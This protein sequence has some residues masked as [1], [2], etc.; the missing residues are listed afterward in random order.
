MSEAKWKAVVKKSS[1]RAWT[2]RMLKHSDIC[3]V[4]C[5]PGAR[6]RLKEHNGLSFGYYH[7]PFVQRR[8]YPNLRKSRTDASHFC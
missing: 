6:W 2:H 7:L 3:S 5:T 4:V 8:K 1:W